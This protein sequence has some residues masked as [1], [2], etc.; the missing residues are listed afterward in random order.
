MKLTNLLTGV[1]A[2]A[3]LTGAANAQIA[4]GDQNGNATNDLGASLVFSFRAGSDRS[5]TDR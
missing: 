1:A 3:L 2:A 5:C 4:S